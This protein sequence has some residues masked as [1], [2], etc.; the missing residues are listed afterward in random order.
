[1]L[2]V[3]LAAV[4]FA[5][6]PAAPVTVVTPDRQ[7]A[8]GADT[9][10]ITGTVDGITVRRTYDGCYAATVLRWE[11]LLGIPTRR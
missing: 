5:T 2:G 9:M 7:A 11:R 10:R 4:V 1:M 3:F 8:A 6:L